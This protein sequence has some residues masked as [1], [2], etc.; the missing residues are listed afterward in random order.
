MLW[1]DPL[2]SSQE[3]GE[4]PAGWRPASVIPICRKSVRKDPGPVWSDLVCSVLAW[5]ELQ[6]FRYKHCLK[7]EL[8]AKGGGSWRKKREK[9]HEK[10]NILDCYENLITK[11]PFNL[12]L[13]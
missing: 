11:L 5:D 13:D 10:K 2:L 9:E 6:Y 3:A 7:T 4:V 8:G 12:S 1:Q